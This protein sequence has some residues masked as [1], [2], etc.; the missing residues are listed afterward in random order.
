MYRVMIDGIFSPYGDGIA[1]FNFVELVK[2]PSFR[3]SPMRGD[4][5]ISFGAQRSRLRKM[6]SRISHIGLRGAFEYGQLYVDLINFYNA[7]CPF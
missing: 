3:P 4:C 6:N 5:H 7:D 1:D 2:K